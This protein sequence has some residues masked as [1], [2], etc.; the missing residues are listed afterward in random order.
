MW[1]YVAAFIV[2]FV[3]TV[4]V[5]SQDQRIAEQG[6]QQT[7]PAANGAA[8]SRALDNHARED[9]KN[10][11]WFI[12]FLYRFFMWP[13]G[14][15]A[16]AILLTLLAIAEQTKQTR[17]A[18]EAGQ[19]ATEAMI[20]SERAWLIIRSSMDGYIPSTADDL[21]YWWVVENSGKTPARIIETQCR[22]E[23]IPAESLTTLPSTPHYPEPIIHNGFLVAPGRIVDFYTFLRRPND[24]HPVV[25]GEI[26]DTIIRAIEMEM[27]YLRVYGYVRYFDGLSGDPRE[28]RFC[29]YYVWPLKS[30]PP[31]A[32]GFRPMLGNPA[33][34]TKCT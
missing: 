6:V 34:Y 2:I 13:E 10:P 27:M 15:T 31:R 17:K 3:L 21:R 12:Q 28:S 19:A 20:A 33:E 5:S 29:D 22:Y 4:F 30:R 9:A 32:T 7:A 25:K 1:K 18:A 24:G 16:W 26:D 11:K 14:V 8:A 23:L